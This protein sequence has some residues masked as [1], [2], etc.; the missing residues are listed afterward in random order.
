MQSNNVDPIL[1][2]QVG[3]L[4]YDELMNLRNIIL[5]QYQSCIKSVAAQMR[6]NKNPMAGDV[7]YLVS[8]IEKVRKTILKSSESVQL[9]SVLKMQNNNYTRTN[10][11]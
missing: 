2:L 4:D 7:E 5:P 11:H 6:R 10:Y 8:S 9:L 1:F 3:G